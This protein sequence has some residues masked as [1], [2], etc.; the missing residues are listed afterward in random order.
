MKKID[1]PISQ[2]YSMS[3]DLKNILPSQIVQREGH[4]EIH[5]GTMDFAEAGSVL[6]IARQNGAQV[7]YAATSIERQMDQLLLH[8][9][10]GPFRSADH[11]RDFFVQNILQSSG[12][13]YA[14]K[15]DTVAKIIN[16]I[17]LLEGIAKNHLASGLKKI[18]TWRN[19]FAHGDIQY[20]LKSG[21]MLN[22]FSGEKQV[23]VLTDD[24]WTEV[25][26]CYTE[27]NKLLTE[28][29]EKLIKNS[30]TQEQAI[31]KSEGP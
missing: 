15:R 14:F 1:L 4:K 3:L 31:T 13:T 24:Y 27:S 11:R 7:V 23:I 19:A 30:G 26:Q 18:M 21:A 28:A 12:L 2:A 16:E 5:F 9:F 10:F 22:F 17:D 8:Y 20:D 29:L 25:E 6:L